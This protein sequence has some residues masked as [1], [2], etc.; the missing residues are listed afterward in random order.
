M[1]RVKTLRV[2]LRVLRFTER[3]WVCQTRPGEATPMD[4]DTGKLSGVFEKH[5]PRTNVMRYV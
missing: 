4:S 2:S 1:L 5:C 3:A